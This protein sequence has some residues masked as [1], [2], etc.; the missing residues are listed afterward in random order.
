MVLNRVRETILAGGVG[1][2]TL[3]GAVANFQ[4]FSAAVAVGRTIY[5][6]LVD[7][8]N[9]ECGIGHLSAST[10][11][12][13]DTVIDGSSGPG[14]PINVSAG[15]EVFSESP[16]SGQ[17]VTMPTISTITTRGVA[18]ANLLSGNIGT[19]TT[20]TDR[21]YLLPV[22]LPYTGR[23]TG[24][25]AYINAVATVGAKCRMG[26]YLMGADSR[27]GDL[28][29]ESADISTLSTGA[30]VETFPAVRLPPW[31]YLAFAADGDPVMRS[32]SS[33]SAVYSPV[34]SGNYG[35]GAFSGVK[36]SLTS[37]WTALPATPSALSANQSSIPAIILEA[38]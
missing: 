14:S 32:Y 19:Y 12:V 33:T 20:V 15:A 23:I 30:A 29:Y 7:G 16:A 13:R 6:W 28:I 35:V 21:L 36:Q 8:A 1:D 3:A 10:T 27:P 11:L 38:E 25:R 31:V 22:Q 17:P 26:I 37:G 18:P 9:W 34:G 4:A 2:V 5:Y 24:I